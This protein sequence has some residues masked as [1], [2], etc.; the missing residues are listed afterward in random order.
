MAEQPEVG[1]ARSLQSD[2]AGTSGPHNR[3]L[4]TGR[5]KVETSRKPFVAPQIKEEASLV[6][7]T[8]TSCGGVTRQSRRGLRKFKKHG[9]YRRTSHR[10]QQS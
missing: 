8:L 1:E 10:G 4:G 3:S 6:D 9:S 7:V 2:A 5:P